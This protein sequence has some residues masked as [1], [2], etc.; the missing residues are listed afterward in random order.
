MS[1][2]D[3]NTIDFVGLHDDTGY[4]VL[5]ISDHLP[6]DGS[7]LMVL[8][9][10]LNTYIEFIESGQLYESYPMAK[11][12]EIQISLSYKFEPDEKGELFL[13]KVNDFFKSRCINFVY[14]MPPD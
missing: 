14:K 6:W 8:Q 13:K 12:R 5:T 7:H 2:T 10:K 1:V 9:N 3:P 4:V 11:N